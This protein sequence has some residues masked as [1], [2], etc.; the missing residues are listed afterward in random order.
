[1]N[2]LPKDLINIIYEYDPTKKINMDK[3]IT[4]LKMNQVIQYYNEFIKN[5]GHFHLIVTVEDKF[6]SIDNM[7]SFALLNLLLQQD[8]ENDVNFLFV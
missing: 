4:E 2:H 7:R 3:V 6:I 8:I 1:M 5:F